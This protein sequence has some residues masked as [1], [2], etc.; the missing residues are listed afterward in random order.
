MVAV[1]R[2]SDTRVCGATTV[3]GGQTTVFA[4]SLL[5]AVNGD[6]DSHGGGG[7]IAGSNKVFING[8]AV[9]NNTPDGS[10]ADN[11]CPISPHCAPVLLLEV[12]MLMW[13][14]N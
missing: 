14:I 7:L 3:V 9:V 2:H 4:N 1:H 6:P 8:I 12:L 5:I 11:L 13:V 10:A